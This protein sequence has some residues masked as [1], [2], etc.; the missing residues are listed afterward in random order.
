VITL[1]GF[2]CNCDHYCRVRLYFSL[3]VRL[4]TF[5]SEQAKS[6]P[7]TVEWWCNKFSCFT[8]K[9]ISDLMRSFQL[10]HSKFSLSNTHII[11]SLKHTHTLSLSITHTLSLYLLHTHTHI[12]THFFSLIRS[13]L[14]RLTSLQMCWRHYTCER[15]RERERLCRV[16]IVSNLF[17]MLSSSFIFPLQFECLSQSYERELVLKDKIYHKSFLLWYI[18]WYK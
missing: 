18:L 5:Y 13:H 7:P 11:Y 9:N 1:S 16:V 12:R 4:G 3:Y 2:Y 14:S 8:S 17:M 15:E 10:I 6:R